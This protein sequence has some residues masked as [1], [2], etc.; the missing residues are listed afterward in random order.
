MQYVI[1]LKGVEG[2]SDI[3]FESDIMSDGFWTLCPILRGY[4]KINTG[5]KTLMPPGQAATDAREATP[6]LLCVVATG[7][8]SHK[9]VL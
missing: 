3:L 6:T 1:D 5:I 7:L 8:E 4:G 9:N 2:V